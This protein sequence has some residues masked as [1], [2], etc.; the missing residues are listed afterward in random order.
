MLGVDPLQS[1]PSRVCA[2]IVIIPD[3]ILAV[4]QKIVH[5]GNVRI[6][7]DHRMQGGT[8]YDAKSSR[9]QFHANPAPRTPETTESTQSGLETTRLTAPLSAWAWRGIEVAVIRAILSSLR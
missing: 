6:Q 4:K 2:F 3:I 9:Q 1:R 5:T 7:S 8:Y